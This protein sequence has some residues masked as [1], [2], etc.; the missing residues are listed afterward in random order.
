MNP[1]ESFMSTSTCWAFDQSV[2]F[3]Q[4]NCFLFWQRLLKN[5]LILNTGRRQKC[6]FVLISFLKASAIAK[7]TSSQFS[8]FASQLHCFNKQQ[9]EKNS[10]EQCFLPIGKIRS[11]VLGG[12]N[13]LKAE[14]GLENE[15][16]SWQ[17]R[18][19]GKGLKKGEGGDG[20]WLKMNRGFSRLLLSSLGRESPLPPPLLTK[21]PFFRI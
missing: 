15:T 21:P 13:A 4:K 3:W 8:L 1:I 11:L 14:Y 9:N 6:F 19:R 5:G 7:S 17:L 10:S 16:E 2:N 20:G 18:S 12:L